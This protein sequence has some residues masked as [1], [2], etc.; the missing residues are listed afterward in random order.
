MTPSREMYLMA[1]ARSQQITQST[2]S[3]AVLT[4]IQSGAVSHSAI[5]RATGLGQVEINT[6]LGELQ[7]AGRIVWDRLDWRWVAK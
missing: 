5:A 3:G 7:D 2:W 6:A 1:M 4:A